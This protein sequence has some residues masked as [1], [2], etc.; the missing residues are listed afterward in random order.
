[1]VGKRTVRLGLAMVEIGRRGSLERGAFMGEGCLGSTKAIGWTS[2]RIMAAEVEW[3]QYYFSMVL[4]CRE[5]E[6]EEKRGK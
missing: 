1:M 5:D 6:I 3:L 2:H 4:E